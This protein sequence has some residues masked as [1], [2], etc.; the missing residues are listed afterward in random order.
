[1]QAEEYSNSYLGNNADF[2]TEQ[3]DATGFYGL[4][5]AQAPSFSSYAPYTVAETDA[6]KMSYDID[7]TKTG[8]HYI[9]ARV[10]FPDNGSDSFYYG[11]DNDIVGDDRKVVT[12]TYNNWVWDSGNK[13]IYISSTGRHT[14]DIYMRET[15]AKV[16][17]I[18]LTTDASYNPNTQLYSASLNANDD[19]TIIAPEA[20][21][22]AAIIPETDGCRIVTNGRAGVVSVY[23]TTGKQVAHN[24]SVADNTFIKLDGAGVYIVKLQIENE[25]ITEKV[26][27][28]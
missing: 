10:N 13:S 26:V 18:V 14:L 23:D 20:T 24:G 4:G 16:D 7:F 6:P 28:N 17:M 12:S 22:K 9:W 8:T 15:G 1:M 11:I 19:I 3:D 27:V 5:Y 21:A 25:I 2:W